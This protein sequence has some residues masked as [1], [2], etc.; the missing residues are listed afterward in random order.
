[1]QTDL[2]LDG[3]LIWSCSPYTQG[4]INAIL[5]RQGI[6]LFFLSG[7]L[8]NLGME[9]QWTATSPARW[10]WMGGNN[11]VF[12][13]LNDRWTTCYTQKGRSFVLAGHSLE[14][15]GAYLA[16]CKCCIIVLFCIFID[17]IFPQKQCMIKTT[18]GEPWTEKET[19]QTMSTGPGNYCGTNCKNTFKKVN[20]LFCINFCLLKLHS[21]V[22]L[23]VF[24][25][26]H[27]HMKCF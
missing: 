26:K 16:T 11:L 10:I 20:I 24:K 2:Q 18:K 25:E 4:D 19:L 17:G 12:F 23:F 21:L 8:Y 13:H 7:R 27:C 6:R 5:A 9:F 22:I 14:M 15:A 3:C 1:M